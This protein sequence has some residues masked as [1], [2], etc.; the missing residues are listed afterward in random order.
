MGPLFVWHSFLVCR[1][2]STAYYSNQISNRQVLFSINYCVAYSSAWNKLIKL[3]SVSTVY[4]AFSLSNAL[5]HFLN[6]LW[7]TTR[8]KTRT[9]LHS[10]ANSQIVFILFLGRWVYWVRLFMILYCVLYCPAS[11]GGAASI[12]P[13]IPGA[14]L[15][16]PVLMN[17]LR[18]RAA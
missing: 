13:N 6:I 10:C 4:S 2:Y 1:V 3:H 16:R 18:F 17:S 5:A 14:S 9:L 11:G 7:K 15:K 8:E 12:L